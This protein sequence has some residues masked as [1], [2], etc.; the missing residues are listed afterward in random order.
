[1]RAGRDRGEGERRDE[2]T[3]PTAGSTLPLPWP[4]CTPFQSC[5][6]GAWPKARVWDLTGTVRQGKNVLALSVAS[7]AGAFG[8]YPQLATEVTAFDY[9]A[10]PPGTQE[11]LDPKQTVDGVY[12]FPSI[13]N[14]SLEVR[15]GKG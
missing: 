15:P 12:N 14:F 7:P 1:M 8:L 9:V 10:Q 11:P 6:T 3:R 2:F 4:I 13:K 5:L